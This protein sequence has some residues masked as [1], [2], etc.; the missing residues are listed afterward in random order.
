MIEILNS[1]QLKLTD[2]QIDRLYQLMIHAY[3]ETEA[4]IWGQNYKRLEKDEY[5]QLISKEGFL[6]A[7]KDEK[8]V[9]SIYTYNKNDHTYKFGLLNVDFEETG[10]NIGK[11]LIQAAEKF[12]RS[13]GAQQMQ[14]EILRAESPISEFK[15]WLSHWYEE[16]G[17]EFAG[18]HPFEYIEPN[19]PEKRLIMITEVMFDIYRKPLVKLF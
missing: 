17:Y 8:I 16:Q 9:G 11:K 7:L 4:D 5:A 18:T 2:E 6:I 3:A 15:I 12:A 14:L 1:H 13:K 10:Q 19:R